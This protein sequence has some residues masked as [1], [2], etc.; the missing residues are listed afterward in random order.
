[1]MMNKLKLLA[2]WALI[3]LVVSQNNLSVANVGPSGLAQARSAEDYSIHLPLVLKA[4][5]PVSLVV[6]TA[7]DVVNGDTASPD[8][9]IADPGTDGI[10]LREAILAVN[11]WPDAAA[12]VI[13]FSPS[14][15]GSVISLTQELLI[16]Q[17]H[18]TVAGFLD[19]SG[20]PAIAI[21]IN[22]HPRGGFKV[23]GS[24]IAIRQ[25]RMTGLWVG[26][27]SAG[28]ALEPDS[29]GTVANVSV[30]GNVF[31]GG[32][33]ASSIGVSLRNDDAVYPT[34]IRNVSIVGNTFTNFQND[35]D[36]IHLGARGSYSLRENISIRENT[37]LGSVFPIELEASGTGNRI[38]T[39]QIIRNYFADDF[40]G[41]SIGTIGIAGRPF[42]GNV[43][44][45]TLIY[46]NLF[47]TS[48]SAVS[49]YAGVFADASQNAV[50]HTRII[51]NVIVSNE[52]G[53]FMGGGSEGGAQNVMSDTLIARNVFKGNATGAL[54]LVA[55]GQTGSSGNVV[56]STRLVN[57]LMV[58]NGELAI[59][60]TGGGGGVV[61]N[62]VDGLSIVNNTIAYN[63]PGK[64]IAA[65]S[66]YTGDPGNVVSGVEVVNTILWGHVTDLLGLAP[67]HV[68]FSVT[69]QAG[70]TGINGN[71]AA[72]PLFVNHAQGDYHLSAGSS[73][74]D[75]GTSAEVPVSDLECRARFDDPATPD[76]GAGPFTF[77]DMGAFEFQGPISPCS[78][79]GQ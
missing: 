59:S 56:Q 77:Y 36:C 39:V 26:R 72:D 73:A 45:D 33:D 21:Q 63:G 53:I 5:P 8:A 57:N 6:A 61:D 79:D 29:G 3:A 68:R 37:F 40:Q 43:I 9:L 4:Y 52:Q 30:E 42:T 32:G 27:G 49:M 65:I 13:T 76:T 24:Y 51:S 66:I 25:L 17:D 10:A 38:Q 34:T 41:V 74:I 69:A 35:A 71:I 67:E 50:Y 31:E 14:L 19:N 7:A 22:E 54:S 2:V 18:V 48:R 47:T 46:D 55:G 70:Y 15:A 44:S 11:N 62:R 75:A 60:V 28:V 20:Q 23:T 1:M 16:T 58:D 64:T 12:A 78:L